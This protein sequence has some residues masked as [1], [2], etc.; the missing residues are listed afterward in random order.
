MVFSDPH[1]FAPSLFD[2]TSAS[3]KA[4]YA[5]EPKLVEYS[6]ELFDSAVNR[7]I[8]AQPDILLIPGDLTKD[9]ERASHEYVADA[10]SRIQNAGTQVFVIPGNHDI[11]NPAAK[12]YIESAV[13]PIDN[14]SDAEFDSIYASFGHTQAVQTFGHNYLSYPTP[15][16]A[17]IGINSCKTN[18]SVRYSAG[19]IDEPTMQWIEQAAA[20]ATQSGRIV[21]A[22]M[23]HQIMPHFDHQADIAPTYIA[24]QEASYPTLESIQQ[25][26]INA[27]IKVMLTGHYHIHSIQSI[28]TEQGTLYD[29]STG[30]TC[31]FP[32]PLR[33]LIFSN[34]ILT[35]ASEQIPLYHDLEQQRN[36]NT[37]RGGIN[38]LAHKFYPYVQDLQLMLSGLGYG[39][40]Y[41]F[42]SNAND[43]ANDLQSYLLPSFAD[44]I[45][46]LS[47][48][49]EDLQQDNDSTLY[50]ACI[51][52]LNDY[53]NYFC[54]NSPSRKMLL[55]AFFYADS[56][57]PGLLRSIVGSIL[58][59]Y[60]TV[61]NHD[62]TTTENLVPDG[63]ASVI[64]SSS[65]RSIDTTDTPTLLE[66]TVGT[67]AQTGIYS[68]NGQFISS[69]ENI[70]STLPSGLYIVNSRII[71]H[72][73]GKKGNPKS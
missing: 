65:T 57:L 46:R 60:V 25:R 10:L 64:L 36:R 49:D 5:S 27:G 18:D 73:A 70:L 48:G 59:N 14:I 6:A 24:N 44:V 34:G 50:H 40:K 4:Y 54:Y 22:M 56:D 12:A 9:G 68:I 26:L 62:G 69:D 29:I 20:Q 58:F 23:H 72:A 42:P 3:F 47:Q 32:S 37:A 38:A 61:I 15:D 33:R 21:I 1:V 7:I 16:L 19:G 30:S 52:G 67:H 28:T 39:D 63:A 31:S 51:N 71:Y 43:L 35:V 13:Q 17:I 11:S 66:S 2:T 55:E 8:D 45:N 41:R 53:L